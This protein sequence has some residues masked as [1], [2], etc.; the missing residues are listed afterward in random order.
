M[1]I[2]NKKLRNVKELTDASCLQGDYGPKGEMLVNK[3]SAELSLPSKEYACSK[4]GFQRSKKVYQANEIRK[5]NVE[6]RMLK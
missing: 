3:P 6:H 1:L 4:G 2:S 5:N